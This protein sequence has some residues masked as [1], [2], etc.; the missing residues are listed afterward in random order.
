MCMLNSHCRA[1]HFRVLDIFN[2]LCILLPQ[3]MAQAKVKPKPTVVDGFGLA[4]RAQKPE[5]SKAGLK[6]H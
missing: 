1:M 3:A 5:P 4:H 6:H 2:V